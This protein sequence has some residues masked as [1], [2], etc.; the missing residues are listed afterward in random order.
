M[1][2]DDNLLHDRRENLIP[3]HGSD[4]GNKICQGSRC[5]DSENYFQWQL[6]RWSHRSCEAAGPPLFQLS[7]DKIKVTTVKSFWEVVKHAGRKGGLLAAVD[8]Q[9][10]ADYGVTDGGLAADLE[11]M[12]VMMPRFL[13]KV[14]PFSFITS[15]HTRGPHVDSDVHCNVSGLV[16]ATVFQE[17]LAFTGTVSKCLT[18]THAHMQALAEKGADSEDVHFSVHCLLRQIK[19]HLC[20]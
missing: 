11:N 7:L 12:V 10:P 2:L 6:K 14:A 19:R 3:G 4:S 1:P 13:M 20:P 15:I 16:H 5:G 18:C 8:N 17:F 9:I